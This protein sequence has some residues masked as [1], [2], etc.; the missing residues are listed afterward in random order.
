MNLPKQNLIVLFFLKFNVGYAALFYDTSFT[1]KGEI[2]FSD[3]DNPWKGWGLY[4]KAIHI[5]DNY[6]AF[7]YFSDGNSQASLKFRFMSYKN[8]YDFEDK[9]TRDFSDYNF[10]QDVQ[11]NGFYK[12]TDERIVLFTEEEGWKTLH[13]FLFDFY[14][15]YAGIKIR[16]YKF[17]M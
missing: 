12:L 13:M 2:K 6:A 10:R 16:E 14:D 8:D 1:K 3:A 4:N 9:I 11:A 7:V 5:K 15:N 17:D